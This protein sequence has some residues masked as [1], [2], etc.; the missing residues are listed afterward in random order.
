[1]RSGVQLGDS[2]GHGWIINC[3]CF[4]VTQCSVLCPHGD[5]WLSRPR[6]R[7]SHSQ[8]LQG[9]GEE[10]ELEPLAIFGCMQ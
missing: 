5:W 4:P 2:Q 3:V 8:P 9:H 1:M 6:D 7:G 10:A